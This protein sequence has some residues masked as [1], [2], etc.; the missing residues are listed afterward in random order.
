[1]PQYVRCTPL[2]FLASLALFA[3]CGGGLPYPGLTADEVYALA[4]QAREQEDWDDA[5]R[6]FEFVLF[7]PGFNRAAEAR[8]LLAQVGAA[9][10]ALERLLHDDVRSEP[11]RSKKLRSRRPPSGVRTLS[12]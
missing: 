11:S 4:L 10:Q 8:L 9:H 5:I 3:A 6:A 12:G 7:S 2:L 1:M